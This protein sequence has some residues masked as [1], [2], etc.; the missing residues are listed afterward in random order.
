M[1]IGQPP[2]LIGA[3]SPHRFPEPPRVHANVTVMF[4]QFDNPGT[5]A[6]VCRADAKRDPAACGGDKLD[7][8]GGGLIVNQPLDLPTALGIVEWFLRHNL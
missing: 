3:T 1:A 6:P 8:T 2:D 7:A 4:Q 5:I